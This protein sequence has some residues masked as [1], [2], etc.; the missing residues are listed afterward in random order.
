MNSANA[1]KNKTPCRTSR[2]GNWLAEQRFI[3]DKFRVEVEDKISS[4]MT[5]EEAISTTSKMDPR[6]IEREDRFL[7][8]R[9]TKSGEYVGQQTKDLANNIVSSFFYFTTI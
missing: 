1:K 3:K 5:E 7:K 4:G 2:G 8:A 6:K 9:Q